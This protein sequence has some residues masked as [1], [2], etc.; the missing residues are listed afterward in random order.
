MDR[1][2]KYA[3]PREYACRA[4]TALGGLGPRMAYTNSRSICRAE[5]FSPKSAF[6]DL[7]G[8]KLHIVS[9]GT[10]HT[11]M[12]ELGGRFR[13]YFATTALALDGLL[14]FFSPPHEAG[15][16]N[17]AHQGWLYGDGDG[18]RYHTAKWSFVGL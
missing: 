17:Q 5:R 4:N 6:A 7:G 14:L 1:R 15:G 3:R 12:A 2:C 10:N 9:L 11:D 18:D 16:S 8:S 13:V